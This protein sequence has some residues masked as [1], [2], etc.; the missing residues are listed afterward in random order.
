MPFGSSFHSRCTASQTVSSAPEP[1]TVTPSKPKRVACLASASGSAISSTIAPSAS[2]LIS[3]R[4]GLVLLA[5]GIAFRGEPEAAVGGERDA[6]E[7]EE[8]RRRAVLGD[9][10]GA[11]DDGRRFAS[12]RW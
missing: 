10:D 4:L 7:V 5:L 8:L 3:D 12:H 2:T 6:L 11:G 1:V 9:G